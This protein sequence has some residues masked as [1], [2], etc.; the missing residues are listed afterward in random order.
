MTTDENG[1]YEFP[2]VP[3]GTVTIDFETPD[4]YTPTT[5]NNGDDTLDSDGTTV[6]V[7]VGDKDIPTIDSGFV[8]TPVDL[9]DLGDKVWFDVDKDGIQDADEPGIEGATVTLTKPDG[10]TV[11]TT[12]DENGNY[13]FENLEPGDYTVTFETP[14]GYNGPTTVDSGDDTLDSDGQTV[15]VTMGT[16]D[17]MTIDSGFIRVSVGDTVWE[18]DGDGVQEP[19][20]PGIP[21]VDVTITYPDGTKETVTTDE[22]G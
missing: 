3:P 20:E 8:K 10:T 9:P 4:G 17:N 6:T 21:G 19:G 16:E 11:T 2:N 15:K 7:T 5:P 12:T 1:H 13:I 14:E 18:D 22:N